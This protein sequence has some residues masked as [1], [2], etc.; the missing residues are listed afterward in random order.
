VTQKYY[1]D[2]DFGGAF[3]P[4]EPNL[5]YPLNTVTGFAL[6]GTQRN[7][8]PT[9]FALRLT[10][11]PGV[12]YDA[13]ADF[14]TKVQ[15]FRDASLT[16]FWQGQKLFIAGTYFKTQALEPGTFESNQIQAQAGYGSPLQGFS[17]S[18]TL[19]HDIR[20]SKLLSS[21]SRLNYGW[22]CCGVAFEFLQF[23]LGVRK[24][25]RFSFSFTL[26]GIG[27]FGNIKRPESLF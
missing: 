23:D 17:G 5:F 18:L 10:P 11:R 20:T 27:S 3:R 12:S 9:S 6:T 4:G 24:E 2:P 8:A 19:S 26:K 14:D 21:H 1:F 13:R 22:D 16:T 15:Q 7:L 25:S